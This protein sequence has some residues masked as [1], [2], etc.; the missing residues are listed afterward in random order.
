MRRLGRTALTVLLTLG[1]I[2]GAGVAWAQTDEEP[3]D[4]R[5]DTLFN[6]GYDILNRALLW[7]TSR[8]D[9]PYDCTL[10]NGTL[11]VTYG[12]TSE[13]GVIL[14]DSITG[15]SGVVMF[16]N[17]PAEE[18]GDDQIPAEAPIAYSGADGPCGLSGG[19]PT[20]PAG[21]INHGMFMRLFNRLYD[22]E[23]GRGCLVPQPA[24]HPGGGWDCSQGIRRPGRPHRID[25]TRR[26]G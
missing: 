9:G 4:S 17:R 3:V 11:T 13:D 8:L 10:E 7:G 2:A 18:V 24:W 16:P 25:R 15:E 20:G 5:N 23:G 21:Q 12:L 6:F 1:L 26:R 22:G 19:D 14:V